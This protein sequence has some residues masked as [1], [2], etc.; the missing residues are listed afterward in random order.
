MAESS[1]NF[2]IVDLK[3]YD[4][5]KKT[6]HFIPVNHVIDKLELE[7]A[8]IEENLK[9]VESHLMIGRKT[10]TPTTSVEPKMLQLKRCGRNK[11]KE[12]APE[13]F[14]PVFSEIT[15]RFGLLF[16]SDRIVVPEELKREVVDAVHFRHSGSTKM[17]VENNFIWCSGL[18]KEI[19]NKC[20]TCTACM[21]S[22]KTLMYQVSSMEKYKTTGIDRTR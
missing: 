10:R 16:V 20:S 6:I 8:E 3:D 14:T 13:E 15:G 11:Q 19:E 1:S 7:N 18:K 4:I 5:A 21:S 17:I 9:K 22:G 12:G 2:L